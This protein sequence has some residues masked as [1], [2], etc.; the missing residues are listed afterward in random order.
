MKNLYL[1]FLAQRLDNQDPDHMA[2]QDRDD[3]VELAEKDV[4][5][6]E[7]LDR[8]ISEVSWD[9]SQVF[10]EGHHATFFTRRQVSLENALRGAGRGWQD[11]VDSLLWSRA[12]GA[13]GIVARRCGRSPDRFCWTHR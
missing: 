11:C 5:E 10:L 9:G 1:S 13:V 4:E 6:R 8:H 7:K 3:L 2:I 12:A